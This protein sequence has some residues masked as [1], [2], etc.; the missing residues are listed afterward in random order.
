MDLSNLWKPEV[1]ILRH[2]NPLNPL[3]KNTP[4]YKTVFG[5]KKLRAMTA[6]E[7]VPIQ[8]LMKY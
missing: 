2:H 5:F 7:I 4:Y 6:Y 8:L 3:D 1:A